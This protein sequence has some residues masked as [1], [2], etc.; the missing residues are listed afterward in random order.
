MTGANRTNN[1]TN[2]QGPTADLLPS[3]LGWA[4]AYA[5]LAVAVVLGNSLTIAAFSINRKLAHARTNYFV[6]SLGIA[7][8]MVG[9]CSIPMYAAELMFYHFD[10]GGRSSLF[11]EIYLPVDAFM[12]LASVFT[13]VAIA[14]DRA[15]SVLYP[16]KHKTISKTA[17]LCAIAVIWFHAATVAVLRLLSN[18]TSGVLPI[19]V[20]NYAV[21]VGIFISLI[22][23]SLAYATV[24]H[25]IR[26]PLK[27]HHRNT[28]TQEKKL[29]VTLSIITFVFVL[30][31]FPFYI[32]NVF[33][34]F[35]P[36]CY[37]LELVYF[38]KFLH[39]SNS[40]ANFIIYALKIPKFR[41]TVF[42]ILCGKRGGTKRPR[43]RTIKLPAENKNISVNNIEIELNSEANDDARS[44]Q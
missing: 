11:H 17:Y 29:A 38:A 13:L 43:E 14:V 31:W 27:L 15:C 26:N 36:S 5:V 12:G 6:V 19:Q 23:I 9:A 3:P 24:W 41:K 10:E 8:F 7:D 40:F 37:V 20:F 1:T 39:Y 16:H 34:M 28:T 18:L 4:I 44:D 32:L 21:I 33:S 25:R 22:T 35:C 2:T 42:K 30:T